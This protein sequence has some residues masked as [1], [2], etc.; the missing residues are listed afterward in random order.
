LENLKEIRDQFG[1]LGVDGTPILNR[2][3]TLFI[4]NLFYDAFSVTQTV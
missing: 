4:C 3:W 1:D 2:A